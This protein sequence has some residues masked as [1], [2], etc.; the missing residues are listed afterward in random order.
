MT[1][2]ATHSVIRQMRQNKNIVLPEQ[3]QNETCV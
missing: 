2:I 3:E 1:A